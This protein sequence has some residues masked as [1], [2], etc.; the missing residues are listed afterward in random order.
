MVTFEEVRYVKDAEHQ[1]SDGG[2]CL[3]V[4]QYSAKPEPDDQVR[5]GVT[6]GSLNNQANKFIVTL[7]RQSGIQYT[8]IA[9][10]ALNGCRDKEPVSQILS[11]LPSRNSPPSR[12]SLVSC[13]FLDVFVLTKP[14]TPCL[15]CLVWDVAR[16]PDVPRYSLL[17]PAH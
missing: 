1:P 14:P 16:P 12:N 11:A 6:Y 15:S 9:I 7:L 2:F 10:D 13:L 4:S 17:F 8:V 3:E 5:P